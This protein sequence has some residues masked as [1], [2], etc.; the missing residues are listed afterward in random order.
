M[1]A[2]RSTGVRSKSISLGLNEEEVAARKIALTMEQVRSLGLPE[3]FER[4]KPK[5][6]KGPVY[7]AKYGTNNV[8]ELDA[9]TPAQLANLL[10]EAIL[11]V[12]DVDAYESELAEEERD[13]E[14][15]AQL[16]KQILK[17]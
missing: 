10:E 1:R 13:L 8:W 17:Q 9:L 15:I 6:P 5:D 16:K 4:V 2:T 14:A 3:S 7:I 11:D 12:I